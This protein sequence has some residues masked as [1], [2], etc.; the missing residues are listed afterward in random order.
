MQKNKRTPR[1]SVEY[2]SLTPRLAWQLAAP[3]TWAAALLPVLLAVVYCAISYSGHINLLLVLVLLVICVLMQS[4]VNVFNDYFDFKKGL[5]S[6]EN[7]STDEFDAVLVY[8]NLRPKSV[9][10]LAV[11]YLALAGLLGVYIIYCTGWIPLV[12]G[13]IGACIVVAYSGGRTPLSYLP[14]GEVVSGF[15]MGGLIP[16]ACTYVLSSVLDFRVLL[17]AIPVMIGIGMILFTN[18]SCDIEKDIPAHRKTLAVILGRQSIVG[19]YRLMVA[20]WL[21]SVI[22]LVG[23]L[24]PAGI[25]VLVFML[26]ALFP[27]LRALFKNPL[28]QASRDAAMSQIVMLNTIVTTFY[29]LA[30]F[31][32]SIITWI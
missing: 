13:I 3:H 4:S 15:V 17:V 5:D 30:L 12:I 21:I 2:S 9:L 6:Q 25:P 31:A 1:P 16:L 18:N 22:A 23:I 8:N 7:S 11:G 27:L 29:C 32:N 14:I 26:L 10:A 24:Y 28:I 20:V 19:T